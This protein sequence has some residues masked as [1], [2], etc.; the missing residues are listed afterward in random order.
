MTV[1]QAATCLH[2]LLWERH[3]VEAA[4]VERP[5]GPLLRVSTHFF[6]TATDIERLREALGELIRSKRA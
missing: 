6:T 4:V 2:R 1:G 5:D 3:R